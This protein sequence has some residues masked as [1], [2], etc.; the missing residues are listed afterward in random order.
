M[1]VEGG[2]LWERLGVPRVEA[3]RAES[4]ADAEIGAELAASAKDAIFRL[5][6]RH[7]FER[8]YVAGGL[9]QF[10]GFAAALSKETGVVVDPDGRFG[11]ERGGLALLAELGHQRGAVV[12]VGQTGIKASMAGRRLVV[13]RDCEALPFELIDP[14]G[15]PPPASDTRLATA[16]AFIGGAIAKLVASAGLRPLALVL[17]L[18][19]P[20]DDACVPGPCTY[21]WEGEARL[22]TA[23]LERSGHSFREVLVL[24]DAELAAETALC[25]GRGSSTLV[26]TL[27]FGPGGALVG[28]PAVL[29][30]HESDDLVR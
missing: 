16:A 2:L 8:A 17:A 9:T 23:I 7:G 3:L 20:L 6:A 27:G 15:A 12:D 22:V 30:Q 26:L 1:Q 14:S 21:G 11:G 24:N 28:G 18:P 29:S 5:R 10:D 19:C 25:R 13:E 4:L